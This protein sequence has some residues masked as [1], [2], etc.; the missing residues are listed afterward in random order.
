MSKTQSGFTLIE[1]M[2]VVVV[3]VVLVAMG[4]PSFQGMMRSSRIATQTNN[5]IGGVNLARGEAIRNNAPSGICAASGLPL[6]TATCGTNWNN[7][8][9][10]FDDVDNS[11]TF[12]PGDVI[13]RRFSAS[14][15]L[16][17]ATNPAGGPGTLIFN[18]R[19]MYNGPAQVAFH[20]APNSCPSGMAEGVRDFTLL[21]VGQLLI[22]KTNCP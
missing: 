20:Q 11:G 8:W 21:T 19:G 7:G 5:F 16:G 13:I 22:N 3:I 12:T 14:T 9:I 6:A 10:V 4:L 18:P 2:I 1:L 15:D 17:I